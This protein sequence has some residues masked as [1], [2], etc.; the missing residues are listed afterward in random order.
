MAGSASFEP[1]TA[2]VT[3]VARRG[4]PGL[5]MARELLTRNEVRHRW[6]DLDRDPLAG[7]IDSRSLRGQRLPLVLSPDGSRLEGIE[8]Y[9]EPA[10]GSELPEN[11][12]R[13]LA[14]YQ[15]RAALA[16]HV[17][18]PTIPAHDRYD[19]VIVGAGPAGLTAAVYAA[20]EGLRALVVERLAPGG[21]AGTSS[22]IENYP[23]FPEGV[24]GGQLA[25][26]TYRQARRLGA[27]FVVGVNIDSAHPQPDGTLLINL[28][29]GASVTTHTGV[30]ATGVTYR[31]L[32]GAGVDDFLGRGV[33]YGSSA[34]VASDYRDCRV[35]VVGGAN[36]AGQAALHLASYAR[37]VTMVIRGSSLEK[38][39][40]R[41]LIERIESHD[42]ITVRTRSAIASAA[43][44]TALERVVVAGPEGDETLDADGL[45]VLI[46]GAP[47]TGKVAGWLRCDDRGYL[48][49]GPDLLGTQ[50]HGWWP[51]DRDP[52][53][54]ESSQPGV[55]VAGDVRCGSM[56]RVASA[57]GEG[58][59]AI[60][61][62][63]SFLETREAESRRVSMSALD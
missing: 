21:Q 47:L 63:H 20:S 24:G 37:H 11:A 7:L 6:V 2:P 49:T 34:G 25:D 13:Y 36:S 52:L 56:K 57:V 48:M 10:P 42:R 29:S 39:M 32:E 44:R 35:I 19:V 4:T 14:S 50:A 51:L 58:A 9:L 12:D 40:S 53:F 38:V 60:A 22:R 18:L 55:F 28:T 3:I 41:Y 54:L 62:V 30:V 8:D 27:E 59:M 61:L 23:G 17:G 45:F 33:H 43:G 15:W 5:D 31:H 16:R 26:F 1:V 46:G